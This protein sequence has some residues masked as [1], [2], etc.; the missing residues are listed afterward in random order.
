MT[1][2]EDLAAYQAA[3]LEHLDRGE[4]GEAILARLRLDPAF[5]PYTDYVDTFEPRMLD[6][7]SELVRKWGKRR[8]PDSKSQIKR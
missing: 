2:G 8:A 7:A 3:L 6:V 5:A 1:A 4:S